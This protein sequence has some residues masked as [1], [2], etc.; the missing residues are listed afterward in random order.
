[1]GNRG[2]RSWEARQAAGL[3]QGAAIGAL[4]AEK[5]SLTGAEELVQGCRRRF[6]HIGR[7]K[8]TQAV[9]KQHYRAY[10]V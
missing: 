1:M 9:D 7:F 8:S 4:H 3:G 10:G 2:W 5:C 6:P